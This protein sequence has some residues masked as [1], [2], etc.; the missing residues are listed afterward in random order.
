MKRFIAYLLVSAL[1]FFAG[2]SAYSPWSTVHTSKPEINKPLA[3][4]LCELESSPERFDGKI[5]QVRA[6]LY[7]GQG[8]ASIYDK[9]CSSP[10]SPMANMVTLSDTTN[11]APVLPVWASHGSF[12]GNEICTSCAV[13]LEAEVIVVGLFH[14]GEANWAFG[15]PHIKAQ[16][17]VQLSSVSRRR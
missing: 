16:S 10:D 6:T 1:S 17:V 9:S 13:K 8:M 11:L 15:Q 3:I 4:S 5:V 12:C 7:R 14:A 2:L